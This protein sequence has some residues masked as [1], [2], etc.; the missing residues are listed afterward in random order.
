MVLHHIQNR[1]D[2]GKSEI[3]NAEGRCRTCE[4][5]CHRIHRTGNPTREQL[6][7]AKRGEKSAKAHNNHRRLRKT[8]GHIL[9]RN[10]GKRRW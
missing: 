7:E 5:L 4:A 6:Y 9:P 2:N 10:R 1:K 3:F 8:P